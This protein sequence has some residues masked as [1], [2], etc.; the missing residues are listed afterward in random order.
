MMKDKLWNILQTIAI[1]AVAL[2]VTSGFSQVKDMSLKLNELEHRVTI[3]E[4]SRFTTQDGLAIQRQLSD[5]RESL[6]RL[7]TKQ[8]MFQK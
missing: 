5:I 4:S 6:A 2:L 3:I 1:G 8:G 7:E